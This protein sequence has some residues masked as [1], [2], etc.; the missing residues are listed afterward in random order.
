M[1]PETKAALVRASAPDHASHGVPDFI[2][3]DGID[4]KVSLMCPC[5]VGLT[6]EIPRTA[7]PSPQAAQPT[8][9]KKG[10]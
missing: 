5:G 8:T 3:Y 4:R 6:I 2:S 10:G 7:Q 9:T 1:G